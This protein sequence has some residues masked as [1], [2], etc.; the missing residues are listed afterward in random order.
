MSSDLLTG[1]VTDGLAER[2]RTD[3]LAWYRDAKR[4]LPWRDLD[5]PYAI[6]VSEIM[7]QQTQVATVR[8]YYVRFLAKFPTVAALAAASVDD[9]YR[10]WQGLGYY[11]RARNLHESARRIVAEYGGRVPADA[12]SL[13]SLPGIG[14]YTAGAVASLAYGI[15]EPILDGNVMRVL[16]RLF[17]VVGDPKSSAT[18]RR[19]WAIASRLVSPDD[20]RNHNAALMELGALVCK[21]THP[22]CGECPLSG[23][24]QANAT[25]KQSRYPEVRDRSQT[26]HV[27]DV[28]ILVQQGDSLVLAKRSRDG[29]WAGLW[30]LPRVRRDLGEP[31]RSAAR[32]AAK[33]VC[34][35]EVSE[36]MP[37][38]RI[39]HSVTR[40]RVT[41]HG[42]RAQWVGGDPEPLACDA[43]VWVAQDE[44][45]DY[46]LSNPQ[47]RL[48]SHAFDGPGDPTLF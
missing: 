10:I 2:I 12:R 48:L 38:A 43:A 37:F 34:G 31:L 32:R 44:L 29:L 19:L 22:K 27:E 46:A 3:L 25:D 18:N 8:D 6:L 41:L 15:A 11:N 17:C 21:P 9:V 23:S 14:R 39:R 47:R 5:D 45:G 16:A 30:E 4:D 7:L 28:A 35:I 36:P 26:S 40:H 24:C 33:E 13:R 1:D 20:P 42:L